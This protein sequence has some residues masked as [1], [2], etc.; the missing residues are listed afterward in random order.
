M[1]RRA[2]TSQV[3]SEQ[4]HTVG[5]HYRTALAKGDDGYREA[6]AI[7]FLQHKTLKPTH[8]AWTEWLAKEGISKTHA[9][10]LMDFTKRPTSGTFA[11]FCHPDPMP[12]VEQHVD[13]VE[14]EPVEETEEVDEEPVEEEEEAEAARK[15][16]AHTKEVERLLHMIVDLGYK[17][18]AMKLRPD[19]G[20]VGVN[21]S[22]LLSARNTLVGYI[23]SAAREVVQP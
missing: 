22:L 9:H 20:G 15:R 4:A 2:P 14:E 5:D 23:K 13:E 12:V 6:G 18:T 1:S 19:T 3:E 10:R 11:D 21:M 16:I 8:G 17:A 7:L